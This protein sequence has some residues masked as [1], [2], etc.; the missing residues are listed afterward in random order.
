[1]DTEMCIWGRYSLLQ[2]RAVQLLLYRSWVVFL[3]KKPD[4]LSSMWVHCNLYICC[5]IFLLPGKNP[6]KGLS[7]TMLLFLL[8]PGKTW[9]MRERNKMRDIL[10]AF[11]YTSL[12][13][14]FFFAT[15]D[16]SNQNAVFSLLNL[17]T[18]LYT[19][20]AT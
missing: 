20:C 5:Y 3:L 17:K 16:E 7:C 13:I 18:L 1:M 2:R 6:I 4:Y 9:E 10:C 19:V 11:L 14:C 12:F 15:I 8:F